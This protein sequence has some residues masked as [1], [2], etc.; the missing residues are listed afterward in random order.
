M[1]DQIFVVQLPAGEIDRNAQVLLR[2][3]SPRCQ[4]PTGREDHPA[5]NI[6]DS[7]TLLGQR[8][9]FHRRQKTAARMAP[10]DERLDAL[11]FTGVQVQLR[12]VEEHEF[13]VGQGLAQILVQLKAHDLTLLHA[14]GIELVGISALFLGAV[15]GNVCISQQCIRVQAALWVYRNTHSGGNAVGLA[16]NLEGLIKA[17]FDL[18]QQVD[19]VINVVHLLL[20]EHELIAPGVGHQQAFVA[21][22]VQALGHFDEQFIPELVAEGV[23]ERLETVQIQHHQGDL[24]HLAVGNVQG[25]GQVFHKEPTIGQAG[26][27]IGGFQPGQILLNGRALLDF[28]IQFPAGLQQGPVAFQNKLHQQCRQAGQKAHKQERGKGQCGP[29]AVSAFHPFN[30]WSQGQ[31]P[32]ECRQIDSVT[33]GKVGAYRLRRVQLIAHLSGFEDF[34]PERLQHPFGEKLAGQHFHSEYP[35][36]KTVVLRAGPNWRIDDHALA[37]LAQFDHTG[38]IPGSGPL[39]LF[40]CSAAFFVE[41]HVETDDLLITGIRLQPA[42]NEIRINPFDGLV[43]AEIVEVVAGIPSPFLFGLGR[44]CFQALGHAPN[45]FSV[46]QEL[47]LKVVGH[48]PGFIGQIRFDL[49]FVLL[50]Q[51]VAQAGCEAEENQENHHR[52]RRAQ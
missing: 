39:C 13:I 17:L 12:L 35:R 23:I 30:R 33:L 11:D 27:G 7:A 48:S 21:E 46:N 1:V 19:D 3:A 14:L 47:P 18:T 4:L 34:D 45:G 31:G 29:V 9:E 6:G 28:L 22:T 44:I 8:D 32:I 5:A 43:D 16:L 52:K 15:E 37:A 40:Q 25:V 42:D 20:T 36:H 51:S 41:G 24:S 50:N 2:C 38:E 26:E 49:T 10:A